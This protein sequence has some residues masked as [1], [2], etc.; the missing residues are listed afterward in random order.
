MENVNCKHIKIYCWSL[1]H[2]EFMN[3]KAFLWFVYKLKFHV[4]AALAFNVNKIYWGSVPFYQPREGVMSRIPVSEV[5]A[6]QSVCWGKTEKARQTTS[7]SWTLCQEG[8]VLPMASL[9]SS[10][11]PNWRCLKWSQVVMTILILKQYSEVLFPLFSG[12][13][14][15]PW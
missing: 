15:A 4:I 6:G 3:L 11:E 9:H 13:V 14:S 5:G 1:P 2:Q 12:Q 7:P 8:P 10:S